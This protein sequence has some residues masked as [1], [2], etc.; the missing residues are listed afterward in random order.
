MPRRV[1]CSVTIHFKRHFLKSDIFDSALRRHCDVIRW[2]FVL[3]LGIWVCI[4]RG[5]HIYTMHQ[6]DLSG[7]QFFKLKSSQGVGTTSLGK[8]C[9]GKGFGKTRVNPRLTKG[10]VATPLRFFFFCFCFCFFFFFW[11][12][13]QKRYRK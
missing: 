1:I 3:I 13:T 10:V 12:V 8:P 7:V 11:M 6:L 4:E 9:Y 5:A 2:M